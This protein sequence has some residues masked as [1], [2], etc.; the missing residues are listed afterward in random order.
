MHKEL[1]ERPK[2]M[3]G[4]V[5]HDSCHHVRVLFAVKLSGHDKA[6]LLGECLC[7]WFDPGHLAKVASVEAR[8][9]P[10]LAILHVRVFFLCPFFWFFVVSFWK[11]GFVSPQKSR[12][13][14]FFSLVNWDSS[15][16]KPRPF[17]WSQ[18]WVLKTQLVG[19]FK[20]FLFSLLFGE[21][22][23]FD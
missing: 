13:L 14:K 16:W 4:R 19:G 9:K 18:I 17:M 15:W 12:Y 1:A 11:W 20:Y 6:S 21:D 23:Q 5:F 10:G 3:V 7:E 2:R 22:F 8:L